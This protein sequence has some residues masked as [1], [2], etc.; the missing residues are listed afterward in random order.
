[1]NTSHALTPPLNFELQ[2]HSN[3]EDFKEFLSQVISKT[4]RKNLSPYTQ[5]N[6]INNLE[7][8]FEEFKALN[9]TSSKI[10][11]FRVSKKSLPLLRAIRYEMQNHST[12]LYKVNYNKRNKPFYLSDFREFNGSPI[13]SLEYYIQFLE[14]N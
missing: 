6:Y 9:L 3:K 8:F 5:L 14:Q 12:L 2:N 10:D 11:I 4:T 1:M 13:A 7:W